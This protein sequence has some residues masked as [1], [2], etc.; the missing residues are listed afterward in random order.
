[1]VYNVDTHTECVCEPLHSVQRVI[2]LKYIE[3]IC[4]FLSSSIFH[5]HCMNAMNAHISIR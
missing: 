2:I 5:W 1:M 4:T 3:Y